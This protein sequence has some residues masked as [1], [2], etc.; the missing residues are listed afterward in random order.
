MF[1]TLQ[2]MDRLREFTSRN[3]RAFHFP[4][5][6][7]LSRRNVADD[8]PGSTQTQG[9]DSQPIATLASRSNASTQTDDGNDNTR[10]PDGTHEQRMAN[11]SEFDQK[12]KKEAMN[13]RRETEQELFTLAETLAAQGDTLSNSGH[14]LSKRVN[15]MARDVIEANQIIESK[16]TEISGLNEQLHLMQL[17]FD[18]AHFQLQ[19]AQN[20]AKQ[21]VDDANRD[22]FIKANYLI[23]EH[24]IRVMKDW[25]GQQDVKRWPLD[26]VERYLNV[27]SCLTFSLH[28]TVPFH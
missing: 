25:V 12:A 4:L 10:Q 21:V 9:P 13:K 2:A 7:S 15:D 24:N 28:H 3:R 23:F 27:R 5:P 16:G 20:L 17:K 22:D 11:Q 19:Q 14:D 18:K 26:K 6:T 1:L 8:S